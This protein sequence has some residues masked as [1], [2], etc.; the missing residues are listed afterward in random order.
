MVPRARKDRKS[1]PDNLQCTVRKDGREYFWYRRPDLPA[2]HAD[3]VQVMGYI[4]EREAIDA[5]RQLNQVFAPGGSIAA[6]ILEKTKSDTK[7]QITIGHYVD[8]MLTKVLPERRIN[9]HPMSARTIEEYTRLYGN[10][11]N[12]I[13]GL[14]LLGVRQSDIADCLNALGSTA[15]VFNKY[16]TRMIDLY[17]NARSD[18]Y[19]VEN[20]PERIIPKDKEPKKRKRITLPGDRPGV[21]GLEGTA[22]YQAIFDKADRATQCAMELALNALQ[23]REEIH[24]WRFDWSYDD[25][26]GRYVYVR[27]SKTHKHGIESYI[28]IPEA[29]P[30]AYS[31][32][33]AETLG[34]LVRACRDDIP[35]PFLVHRRPKR[36][37]K[38]KGRSHP[39]QLLPGQVSNGFADARDAS[40]IYAHLPKEQKPT[41]H[42]LIALGEHLREKQGWTREHL[43]QLRGH[44]KEST[45][46]IYLEGH[47]WSTVEF[48]KSLNQR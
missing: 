17:K 36:V 35:C 38:A 3:K 27:I 26:D 1:W 8:H 48:P 5:A 45:T 25:K 30:T 7:D 40:G 11:K 18:G 32:F 14:P 13:G 42:E 39:F 28:R 21:Y 43:R 44:T 10:I 19:Q 46:K 24:R 41:F 4:S 33:G 20:W 29:M 47:E 34:E 15:E 2:G 12:E 16:R 37:K 31:A 23:R 22:A 6:R 9:G